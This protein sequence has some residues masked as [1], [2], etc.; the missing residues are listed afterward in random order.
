MK[1][2]QLRK[3]KRKEK[4]N[5]VN[6]LSVQKITF[7]LPEIILSWVLRQKVGATP[8]NKNPHPHWRTRASPLIYFEIF[9]SAR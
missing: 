3:T 4:I 9:F 1:L 5:Q 7:P 8:T 6:E 2:I